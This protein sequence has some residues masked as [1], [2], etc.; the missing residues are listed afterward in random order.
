MEESTV[1]TRFDL[2]C[3]VFVFNRERLRRLLEF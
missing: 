3:L 1:S 2:E